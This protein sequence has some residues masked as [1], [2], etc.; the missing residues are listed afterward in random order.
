MQPAL[1]IGALVYMLKDV[2][3][4]HEAFWDVWVEGEVSNFS[5]SRLGHR[6]FSLRDGA[7]LMRAVLFRD[8]MPGVALQDGDDVLVHGRVVIYP[9]RGELQFV[10]DFVR[11]RGV[12]IA[13]AK[14][15]ELQ[16]RLEAEGL[17]APERKRPFPRF[18]QRIGV[19]TSPSGSAWQDIQRVA[20]QRWPLATLV[21]APAL[22]QGEQAAGHVAAAIRDLTRDN[23]LDLLLIARGGGSK[24]DLWAFNDEAVARAIFSCPV[25]V[26]TGVGHEDDRSIA[27]LVAD[28]SASTPSAAVV[29]VTPDVEEMR[30]RVGQFGRAMSSAVRGQMREVAERTA[31]QGR[32]LQRAAPSPGDRARDVARTGARLA[33]AYEISTAKRLARLDEQAARV[34]A[35][36]PGATLRRGYAVVQ[37]AQSGKVVT[38]VRKLKAGDRLGV[39]VSDGAFF[40]EVS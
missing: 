35:L 26:V 23:T 32:R 13:A 38:S 21:L 29:A 36:D 37:H 39:A 3:E 6:Y 8:D 1:K 7:G 34:R 40:T 28:R 15:E 12:G 33:A 9:Q 19:V 10:A 30:D 17:F 5:T 25:P 11:P 20:G 2:I 4:G 31:T 24:E 18:P 14:F 22:V 16:R 27:D